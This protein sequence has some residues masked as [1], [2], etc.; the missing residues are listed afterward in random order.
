MKTIASIFTSTNNP[1]WSALNFKAF[2][3]KEGVLVFPEARW[4]ETSLIAELDI[5]VGDAVE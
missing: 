3:N 1:D 5:K 2:R 4:I